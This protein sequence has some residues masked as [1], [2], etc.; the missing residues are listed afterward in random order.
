MSKLKH[1]MNLINNFSLKNLKG[2]CLS[3][4]MRGFSL[5]ESLMAILILTIAIMAPLAL[6][7]QTLKY[8]RIATEKME[9]TYMAEEGV[10]MLYNV[11]ESARIYCTDSSDVRCANYFNNYFLDQ[12]AGVNNVIDSDC[13]GYDLLSSK[14][15]YC[16]F[17]ASNI[18]VDIADKSVRLS[19]VDT[20][21]D[22]VL[23]SDSSL[24]TSLNTGSAV[25][26]YTNYKR[27]IN[28]TPID[29]AK[30]VS[31][32]GTYRSALITIVVCIRERSVCDEN[33]VNRIIIQDIMSR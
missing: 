10:E 19:G 30:D 8:S 23:K 7:M 4:P 16:N 13:F 25:A 28:I 32:A 21:K 1:M 26:N 17:D 11:K 6:A 27:S 22:Y 9:G 24:V 5:V 33:S 18:V 14:S 3:V 12:E 31:G 15:N 20:S 29:F 2:K